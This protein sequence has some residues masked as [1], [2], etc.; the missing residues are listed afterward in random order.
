MGRA[1]TDSNPPCTCRRHLARLLV[2][3]GR[4]KLEMWWVEEGYLTDLSN[5][6][7]V[8]ALASSY[9][10]CMTAH[11]LA[12]KAQVSVKGPLNRLHF[13]PAQALEEAKN[14]DRLYIPSRYQLFT[15][16]QVR[17]VRPQASGSPPCLPHPSLTPTITGQPPVWQAVWQQPVWQAVCQPV[18]MQQGV[19]RHGSRTKHIGARPL[20]VRDQR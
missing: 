17:Q 3:D 12:H 7:L 5:V 20:S 11:A 15:L 14:R 18:P 2:L 13:C 10:A 9:L 19:G 16:N 4:D 8:P 1:L 6:L